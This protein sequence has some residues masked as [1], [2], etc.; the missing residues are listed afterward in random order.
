MRAAALASCAPA[1]LLAASRFDFSAAISFAALLDA[2]T[3]ADLMAVISFDR[4]VIVRCIAL[5]SVSAAVSAF[6]GGGAKLALAMAPM[7]APKPAANTTE[8]A[9]SAER[10]WRR[11]NA[12]RDFAAGGVTEGASSFVGAGSTSIVGTGFTG[13]M[14][15]IAGEMDGESTTGNSLLIAGVTGAA[16]DDTGV[17]LDS[18]VSLRLVIGRAPELAVHQSVTTFGYQSVTNPAGTARCAAAAGEARQ[19]GVFGL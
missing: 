19:S 13:P 14:K 2:S 8:A 9:S 10:R 7:T 4:W 12:K 16:S 3:L 5:R 11:E 6:G 15:G 17:S 1:V 18:K